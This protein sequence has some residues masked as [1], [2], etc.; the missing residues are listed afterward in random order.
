MKNDPH[1]VS[2]TLCV[3]LEPPHL[4]ADLWSLSFLL[5]SAPT[6]LLSCVNTR[7]SVPQRQAC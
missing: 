7:A 1:A 2:L 3:L 6:Q 4:V 5:F